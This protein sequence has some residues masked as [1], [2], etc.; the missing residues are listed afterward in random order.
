MD[1]DKL[2]AKIQQRM[3]DKGLVMIE[4]SAR[5]VHLTRQD[6]DFLFGE[7]YQLTYVKELSQKGFFVCKERVDLVGPKGE[8]KNVAVLG[9][10]RDATQV[11]ILHAEARQLGVQAP[12]RISGD[13]KGSAPIK[14][15]VGDKILDVP[16]GVMIAKR[17]IHMT[18]QEAK[19][20]NLVQG[21]NVSVEVFSEQRSL[22][23]NDTIIRISDD[24]TLAMH[25][26]V[27]EAN[28]AQVSGVGY[29]LIKKESR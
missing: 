12:V 3:L 15:R 27:E 29:G 18:P 4:I 5:H 16:E 25:I 14:L 1:R 7:G 8:I 2:I 13:T 24:A 10:L 6:V 19:K 11:E 17:H 20:F 9:P 21:E 26:D 23:F 28:S 22:T